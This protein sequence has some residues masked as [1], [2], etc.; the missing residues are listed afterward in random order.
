MARNQEPLTNEEI[1]DIRL[2]LGWGLIL[3]YPTDPKA[4]LKEAIKSKNRAEFLKIPR[5]KRKSILR[6]II[7]E[8]EARIKEALD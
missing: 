5:S 6:F 4:Y 8:A 7:K 1:R 2:W 3:G